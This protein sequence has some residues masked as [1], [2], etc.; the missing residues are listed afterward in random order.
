MIHAF[1]SNVLI[2]PMETIAAGAEIGAGQS[3]VRQAGSVGAA[4]DGNSHRLQSHRL[5]SLFS[6][7]DQMHAGFDHFFHISVLFPDRQCNS[8][9]TIFFVEQFFNMAQGIQTSLKK[10]CVMIPHNIG[11]CSF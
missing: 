2:R 11:E 6:V 8:T 7:V 1:H 10:S 4:A 3:H 9:G 5:H